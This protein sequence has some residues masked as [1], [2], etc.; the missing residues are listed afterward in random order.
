V[1][2]ITSNLR[3]YTTLWTVYCASSKH[4]RV[5][6][7]SHVQWAT[8]KR[9][10]P[11]GRTGPHRALNCCVIGHWATRAGVQRGLESAGYISVPVIS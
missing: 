9:T 8:L 3:V 2:I 7:V 6:M 11:K 4:A 1:S 5:K 10:G